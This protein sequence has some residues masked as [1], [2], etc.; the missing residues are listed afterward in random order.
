[1]PLIRCTQKLLKELDVMPEEKNFPNE[2]L[3]E[4]H[5]NLLL[6]Q[7]RKCV[8]FTNSKTLFSFLVTGLR[9]ADFKHLDEIF[10]Q[11]CFKQMLYEGI[12]QNQFEKVLA[13]NEEIIYGKTNNRS[14]LGSMND[15]TKMIKFDVEDARHV[16]NLNLYKVNK[17]LNQIPMSAIE[18]KS[19]NKMLREILKVKE[20]KDG[21]T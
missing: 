12:P 4:W 5:A 20:N 8:L 13:E 18:Y 14:V 11:S 3:G 17:E 1:M 6:I 19:G 9:K 21:Y 7:R 15:F 16:D 2:V 10:R